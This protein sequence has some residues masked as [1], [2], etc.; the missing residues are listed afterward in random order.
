MLINIYMKQ[1]LWKLAKKHGAESLT[2]IFTGQQYLHRVYSLGPKLIKGVAGMYSDSRVC[3][4]YFIGSDL[5]FE[6]NHPWGYFTLI[7]SGGYYECRGKERKWRGPGWFAWRKHDDFHRVEIPE[8]GHAIT[9]FIKGKRKKN[10]T[11][12]KMEDGTIMKDLK[13]WRREGIDRAM[14]G[15]MIQWRTPQEIHDDI[16]T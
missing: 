14:I 8:G 1:L 3:L 7:L 9:F 16:E 13:Y 11:F 10:S 5:P 6:H 15:S 12:F 4:N 2:N